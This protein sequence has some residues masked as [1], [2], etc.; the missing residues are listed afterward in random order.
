MD[1]R[2]LD[3]TDISTTFDPPDA[4]N[5]EAVA[6]FYERN[7]VMPMSSIGLPIDRPI[8]PSRRPDRVGDFKF[9]TGGNTAA[10]AVQGPS[11]TEDP[12]TQKLHHELLDML[13][14]ELKGL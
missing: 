8:I 11:E 12:E 7:G 3:S 14:D 5:I 6:A 1:E 10:P 13:N 4:D 2:D 9:T